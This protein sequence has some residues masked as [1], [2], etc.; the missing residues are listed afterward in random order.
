[1]DLKSA[2]AINI[3]IKSAI[4]GS[5]PNKNTT[6]LIVAGLTSLAIEHHDS[7][8]LLVEKEKHGSAA[9][10]ARPLHYLGGYARL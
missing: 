9:A 5:H 7:I 2:K 1:M 6:A 8:L 4:S 10:L 3:E